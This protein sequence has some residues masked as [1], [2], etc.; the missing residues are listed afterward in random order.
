MCIK[1]HVL[2]GH[3]TVVNIHNWVPE[4]MFY[5]LFIKYKILFYF[6]IYVS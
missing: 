6:I 1:C 2:F 4:C 3:T 5:I